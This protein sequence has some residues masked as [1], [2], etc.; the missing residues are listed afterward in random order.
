MQ[1]IEC[2]TLYFK[3]AK[4]WEKHSMKNR[5]PGTD[6]LNQN[7]SWEYKQAVESAYQ[8]TTGNAVDQQERLIPSEAEVH[9]REV[10]AATSHE[11]N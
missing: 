2:C 8:Q 1:Q 10:I 6:E 11:N 3:W 5:Q 4:L 7:C 9:L